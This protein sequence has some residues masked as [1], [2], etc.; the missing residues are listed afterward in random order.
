MY[1]RSFLEKARG[2]S[3]EEKRELARKIE[4]TAAY[5]EKTYG[6]CGQ[7]TLAALQEHLQLENNEVFRASTPLSGGITALGE[8]CGAVT[9]VLLV[10]GQL[11]GRDK[12]CPLEEVL[13]SRMSAQVRDYAAEY[14]DAFK[15]EFGS[16]RCRD[17]MKKVF[18]KSWNL[19]DPE[20]MKEFL[21]PE[22]HDDCGNI[23]ARKAGRIAAE[24]LLDLR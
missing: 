15:K 1:D 6:F 3:V 8:V 16:V 10:I 21:R 24:L 18:G 13:K 2:M 4:D 12:F 20:E 14:T 5:N 11:Y 22:V 7:S 17:V 23:I 9:G 19:R